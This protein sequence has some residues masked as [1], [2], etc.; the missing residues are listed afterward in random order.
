MIHLQQVASQEV[1]TQHV[2]HV[3]SL[4]NSTPMK[5]IGI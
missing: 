4:S 1:L 5:E 2:I 3:V